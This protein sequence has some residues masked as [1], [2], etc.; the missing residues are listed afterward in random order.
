MISLSRALSSLTAVLFLSLSIIACGG[1]SSA[2]PPDLTPNSFS[3]A[4]ITDVELSTVIESDPVTISGI[5]DSVSVSITGGEFSINGGAFTSGSG[6]INNGGTIAVRVTSSDSFSTSVDTTITVGGVSGTFRVTTLAEDITPEAFSF[7][8]QT[9]VALSSVIESNE[10]TVSG[11]NTAAAISIA[12]GEYSIGG[13]DFVSTEGT[14]SSGDTVVVRL[15]SSSEYVTQTEATLTIGTESAAFQV[16]TV[17]DTT[18]DAF[19]F[20]AQEEVAPNTQ[21]ESNSVTISGL[22]ISTAISITGGEYSVDGGDFTNNSGNIENGQSVVVRQ[23]AS[24]E[25][26]TVTSAVLTIGDVDGSFDVTTEGRYNFEGFTGAALNARLQT[27]IVQINGIGDQTPISVENGEY[28]LDRGVWTNQ[29]G[30]I[31]D[32]QEVRVRARAG[33]EYNLTTTA[34]LNVGESWGYFSI[35][36]KEHGDFISVWDTTL[37]GQSSYQ[38]VALPLEEGGSY[39]FNVNWGDGT[40]D[41]ITQWDQAETVHTYAQAGEYQIVISGEIVGFNFSLA[42]IADWEKLIEVS[43]WGNLKFL[44][45]DSAFNEVSN[46]TFTGEDALDLTGVTDIS[47]M[48]SETVLFNGAVGNW[49]LSNVTAMRDLFSRTDSFSGDVSRWDVSSVVDME[50]AFGRAALF[51]SDLS[52]WNISNVPSMIGMLNYTSLSVENYSNTLI[53]WSLLPTVMNDVYLGAEGL[54]SNAEAESAKNKLIN[55]YGW[56]IFEQPK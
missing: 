14:V 2:P 7:T 55:D 21:V 8:A 53:G 34:K 37:D 22:G 26:E 18:P 3:F 52:A 31:N 28:Q 43:H 32:G 41:T 5:D 46:F 19:T 44:T 50:F 23:T 45:A 4:E 47:F 17:A 54:V 30:F 11:I 6:T 13:A 35:A 25:V 12:G 9:D 48:F 39:N 51:N 10:I 29:A 33:A 24:A 49:D 42:S 40:S 27:H 20:N 56:T 15:T 38:Q 1:G 16:T 36:T